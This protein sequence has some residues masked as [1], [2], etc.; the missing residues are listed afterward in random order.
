MRSQG[1]G[2]RSRWKFRPRPEKNVTRHAKKS[3]T[4]RD[5]SIPILA[6]RCLSQRVS[7]AMRKICFAANRLLGFMLGGLVSWSAFAQPAAPGAARN[8]VLELDGVDGRVEL[9]SGI[10]R[11]LSE[12]TIEVWVKYNDFD[13]SRFYCYGENQHDLGFG[14]VW[15][16]NELVYFIN[17]EAMGRH[18]HMIKVEN[19]LRPNQWCHLAAVSGP[20]GMQLYL[21]GV[22]AGR[23][24]S[25]A[26]FSSLGTVK[27]HNIGRANGERSYFAGQID[28]FR[29]W[30]RA[31]SAQEIRRDM[32]K[33]LSGH[34][35]GLA[36]L[37]NFD[38]PNK[39]GK[40]ATTN[41]FAGIFFGGAKTVVLELPTARQFVA[42]AM[43][44]GET[45]NAE[46]KLKPGEQA[47]PQEVAEVLT[48]GESGA[49]AFSFYFS[50]RPYEN[51]P[52]RGVVDKGA[53]FI[54]IDFPIGR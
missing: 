50:S 39:P 33:N 43:V 17:R 41:G 35:A 36:A 34:E 38:D 7:N 15:G 46:P 22:L 6:D 37:W 26:S 54:G 48:Q 8:R 11:E 5:F 32:F 19:F 29:V 14:R 52:L 24:D 45:G 51:N 16:S 20:Q 4:G 9:P 40:E 31:R 12:A 1:F 53:G 47:A 21:N 44:F 10:F 2:F 25:T 42:P 23:N 28:E 13:R 30:K 18:L 3:E 27:S 49:A